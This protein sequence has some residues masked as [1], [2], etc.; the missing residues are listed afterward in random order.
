MPNPDINRQAENTIK[1]LI[2]ILVNLGSL[3]LA[4][5]FIVICQFDF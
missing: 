4:G 2:I 5:D 1:S 3:S